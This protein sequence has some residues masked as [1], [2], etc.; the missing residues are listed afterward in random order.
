MI[1]FRLDP[2]SGVPYYRQI[3]DQIRYGIARG[4]L[5]VGEQLPTVRALAVLLSVNPNTI[6]KVYRELEIKQILE[7]HQGTG[8]FIGETEVRI[9]KRERSA[10][11]GAICDEFITIADSYGITAEELASELRRREGGKQRCTR[12]PKGKP[13]WFR[14]AFSSWPRGRWSICC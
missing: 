11:L 13:V 12:H 6:S 14:P 10:K 5:R 4:Q 2:K 3:M 7:T 8:T 1:R 9:S